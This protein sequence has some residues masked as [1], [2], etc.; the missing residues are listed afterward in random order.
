MAETKNGKKTFLLIQWAVVGAV[1]AVIGGFALASSTG[2]WQ[3]RNLLARWTVL[4]LQTAFIIA[5]CL[6][7]LAWRD[8][9]RA[10]GDVSKRS[11]VGLGVLLA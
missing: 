7:I 8:I 1:V 5:L 6:A 3:L 4:S 9:R 10:L 2:N 11:W